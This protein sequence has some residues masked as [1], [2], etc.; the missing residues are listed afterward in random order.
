MDLKFSVVSINYKTAPVEVREQFTFD[1]GEASALLL[2]LKEAFAVEEALL[3]ST[4]NRTELYYSGNLPGRDIIAWMCSKKGLPAQSY[5]SYFKIVEDSFNAAEYLFRVALGLEAHVVGDLQISNQVK[6][7][8]QLAADLNMAGPFLHRLMHTIFYANKRSVQETAFRDGAASVSYAATELIEDLTHKVEAP[9]VLLLGVGEIGKNVCLNLADHETLSVSV[10]NR[11]KSRAQAMAQEHGFDFLP[12]ESLPEA[13]AQ[14]DVIISSVNTEYPIINQA[15]LEPL[16]LVTF[17]YFIDLSV[18]RSVDPEVENIPGV[19]VYNIDQIN[20][21]AN[22]ALQRR[23]AA[24]PEVEKIIDSCLQAFE[25][26]TKEL[27]V[28][29]TIKKLKHALEEIRKEEIGRYLKDLDEEEA[30]KIEL[31]TRGILQKIIKL[32]VLQLKAA[33]KRGE[34]DSVVEVIHDLFNLEKETS[35]K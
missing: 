33:C 3:L 4:C 20:S 18:P 23:L 11:T 6:Q 1:K 26:W 9:K 10:M 25:Q 34:A 2:D 12:F 19:V 32:P 8:Y 13:I 14:S 21:K 22:E 5:S 35:L 29:P 28:S 31:I 15:L 17:K 16:D 30:E 7:A 24:I 27:E